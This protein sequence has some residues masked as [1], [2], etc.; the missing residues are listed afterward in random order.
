[1]ATAVGLRSAIPES[2]DAPCFRSK[3]LNGEG[4][5]GQDD[6]RGFPRAEFDDRLQN[7]PTFRPDIGALSCA[8]LTA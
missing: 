4:S 8:S 2:E 7:W 1:M 5:I 3:Y 6:A